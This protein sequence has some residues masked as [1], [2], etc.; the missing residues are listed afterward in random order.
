MPKKEKSSKHYKAEQLILKGKKIRIIKESDFKKLVIGAGNLGA[1]YSKIEVAPKLNQ[2]KCKETDI[3]HRSRDGSIYIEIDIADFYPEI[4]KD[5][6][7]KTENN[8]NN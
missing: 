1:K 2:K 7:L 5:R 4:M 3:V 6:K 8:K